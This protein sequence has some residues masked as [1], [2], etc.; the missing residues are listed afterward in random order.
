MKMIS[1]VSGRRLIWLTVAI[2]GYCAT[3]AYAQNSFVI[4]APELQNQ[5]TPAYRPR[6]TPRPTP[7][8]HNVVTVPVQPTP[9]PPPPPPTPPEA[10]APPAQPILPAV[11]R[12][13]W[14]GEVSVLDSIERLPGAPPIGYWTPKTYRM[15]YKRV[16]YGPFQLTFTEAGIQRN[17]MITNAQGTMDVISTDGRTYATLRALLHFDEYHGRGYF[18]GSTFPVD[19]VTKLQCQIEPDGMHVIGSVYGMRNT[20]PW[21]RAYWHAVFVHVPG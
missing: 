8:Q 19:E 17:R 11:F 1:S 2:L 20:Q 13:C 6:P 4:P 3:A 14:E 16:G 10:V 12:G 15:C 5:P 7:P 18:S 21:F 9:A